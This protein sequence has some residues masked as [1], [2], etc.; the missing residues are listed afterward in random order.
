MAKDL[1]SDK[2]I[3]DPVH[4]FIR[5]D[6]WER[7]FIE[8][9]PLQRLHYIRQLGIAYLVYPG[10]THSRFEHSLGVMELASRMYSRICK[11]L[12]PDLFHFIPQKGSLEYLYWFKVLRIAALCH[13]MGHVPFSHVAEEDLIGEGGHE[14]W[15]IKIVQSHFLK[16]LW[17]KLQEKPYFQA[18]TTQRNIL[19]DI[20]KVALGEEE[21]KEIFPDKKFKFSSWEK[22]LAQMITGDFFGADRMDYLLRDARCTGVV[23]GLFDH[24]QLIESLRILPSLEKEGELELGIDE[25]GLES[26]EALLLARHFMHK[27][28][29]QYASIK[30]YNFH[31][32]RFMKTLYAKGDVFQSLDAFLDA[33]DNTVITA[34]YQ[35][36]KN[37]KAPGYDDA[38]SIMHKQKR[39]KAI[40]L[41]EFI[42]EKDLRAFQKKESIPDKEIGWDVF[43]SE[44]KKNLSFP[45]FQKNLL[46][47]KASEVSELL[48]R[49]PSETRRWVYIAP[50]YEILFL[51]FLKNS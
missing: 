29:Y 14:K 31:L 15:T 44:R 9:L 17:D 39:F 49:I 4:G 32:R 12:R 11:N 26:C 34:L 47:H 40:S 35:A 33:T 5:F 42:K 21:L 19:E 22:I 8:S 20:I 13:D 6:D 38:M 2:K 37:P 7:L 16:E 48:S 43:S 41:P 50:E 45:V 28:V 25:N 27:R 30:A 3:Y 36:I 10:A 51:Q 18:A 46:I 23:Y 1:L 24:L